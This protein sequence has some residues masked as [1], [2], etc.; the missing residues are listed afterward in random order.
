MR[1]KKTLTLLD[2]MELRHIRYFVAVADTL[3]FTKGAEK[4]RISQPSLT[5]QIRHL[6][7]E[8]GVSLLDRS[9]KHVKLTKQ[10]ERFLIGARRLLN[11]SA[12]IVESLRELELKKS[13]EINI[14]YLPNPRSEE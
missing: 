14:G 10:G 2:L 9:K 1:E 5:R 12:E 3:S 13:A 6:E 11:Y 4:L 7:E 8:L